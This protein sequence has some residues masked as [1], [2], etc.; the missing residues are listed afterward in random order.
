MK[1]IS[2][3]IENETGKLAKV[4]SLL[5]E[6]KVNLRALSIADT[7]DYGLLRIIVDDTMYASKILHD[8]GYLTKTTEVVAIKIE[9]KPGSLAKIMEALCNANIGVEYTYAFTD[10]TPGAAIMVFRVNDN[11]EALIA[12]SNAGIET[13]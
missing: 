4:T 1:Q 9:D 12:L 8:N 3:F 13:L 6:K 5:A 7:H 2:I 10:T 11:K